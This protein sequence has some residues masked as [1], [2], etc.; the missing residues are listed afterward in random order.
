[1]T[2]QQDEIVLEGQHIYRIRC[3]A[4]PARL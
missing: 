1:L 3:R 4:V 2:N